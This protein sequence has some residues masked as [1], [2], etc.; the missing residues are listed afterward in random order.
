MYTKFLN[1]S[2]KVHNSEPKSRKQ[3]C[4][5]NSAKSFIH[6]PIVWKVP[7]TKEFVRLNQE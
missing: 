1:L 4:F 6:M 7:T 5:V 3:A 2:M